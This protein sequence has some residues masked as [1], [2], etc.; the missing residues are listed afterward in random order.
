MMNTEPTLSTRLTGPDDQTRSA[1]SNFLLMSVFFSL[2]HGCVVA[3][4]NISVQL[5]GDAGSYQ[6]G[7][8]PRNVWGASEFS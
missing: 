8:V 2:N 5:L 7:G 6:S 4:L 3:V 1:L